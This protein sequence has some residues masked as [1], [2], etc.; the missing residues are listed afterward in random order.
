MP[1]TAADR[2][3]YGIV[4]SQ[5]EVNPLR[6][7]TSWIGTPHFGGAGCPTDGH[8]GKTIAFVDSG[9]C[10]DRAV[11]AGKV[12]TPHYPPPPSKKVNPLRTITK[13]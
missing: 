1:G 4:P 2:V 9:D 7:I 3:V 13:S 10:R 12:L 5:A 8:T 6:T 11:D